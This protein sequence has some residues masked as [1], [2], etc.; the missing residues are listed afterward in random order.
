[1]V[2]GR[3][4]RLGRSRHGPRPLGARRDRTPDRRQRWGRCSRAVTRSRPAWCSLGFMS[5]PTTETFA[6]Q[7]PG[8]RFASGM[9]TAP[10]GPPAVV[11]PPPP[12]PD[13]PD[14]P[15]RRRRQMWVF[16]G[17]AGAILVIGL[18]I[19]LIVVLTTGGDAFK[20]KASAPTD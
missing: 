9:V 10:G 11:P 12:E 20:S 5:E 4:T 14:G 3:R 8:D 6:W 18:A 7:R 1:M 16:A 19:V 17:I 13:G 2:S 15:D